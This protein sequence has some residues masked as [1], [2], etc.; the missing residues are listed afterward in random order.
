[1]V[2]AYVKHI[3]KVLK[4]KPHVLLAY[5]HSYYMALFAGGKVL[6]R[7]LVGKPGFFPIWK[8]A[9]DEEEA[10]RMATGLFEF[11]CE[12]DPEEIRVRFKKGMEIA[13]EGLSEEEKT[14]E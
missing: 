1:M 2:D 11:P 13:E 8:P 7:L 14:G 5:A 10:R 6:R 12:G 3:E 4:E 9:G